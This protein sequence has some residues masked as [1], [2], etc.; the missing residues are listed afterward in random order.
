[1]TLIRYLAFVLLLVAPVA[2]GSVRAASADPQPAEILIGIYKEAVKGATADWLEPKRR[3]H[4]LSKS[5][6]ALWAKSDAKKPPKGEEGAIDFDLTTDTNA[7]DL[8]DF[9]IKTESRSDSAAVLTVK[10]IYREPYVHEGPPRVMRYEF[11][12]EGSLWRIDDF[13]GLEWSVREILTAWLKL[14]L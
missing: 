12:R 4:Y 7:L 3:G 2:I 10:L 6:L 13:H 11:I 1:M 9:V 14:P 5:L 8:K